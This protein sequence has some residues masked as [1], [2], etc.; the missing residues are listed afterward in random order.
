M[1]PFLKDLASTFLRHYGL[2][3][4][5]FCFVVPNKRSGTFLH[6]YFCQAFKA[7][8]TS[9]D[10]IFVLPRIVTITDFVTEL[11]GLVVDSRIDTLFTLF[12]LYSAKKG[13]DTDFNR[14]RMWGE[15]ALADFN[16]VDMFCVN[17]H[18]LFHNLVS[19]NEIATDYLT[20]EQREVVESY[21]PDYAGRRR[22]ESFW[23]HFNNKSATGVKYLR[24]WET[25]DDLYHQLDAA[26]EKRGLCTSGGAYR[27]ALAAICEKGAWVLPY[28]QVVFVGFNALTTV[29][30][31]IFREIQK[32]E[33][34]LHGKRCSLGDYY[35]DATGEI[36]NGSNSA[37]HFIVRDK[38][39]FP[40]KLKL[41]ESSCGTGS[42]NRLTTIACPGNTVQT[43]VVA[44][45]LKELHNDDPDTVKR[46]GGVVVAM[47][48]EGLFFPMLYSLPSELKEVNITMGYPLKVTATFSWMRLLRTLHAHSR[49]ERG[50]QVFLR[51]DMLIFLAHPLSRAI[52]GSRFCQWL[53][54]SIRG[55]N[56]FMTDSYEISD[57]LNCDEITDPTKRQEELDRIAGMKRPCTDE[58]LKL[59]LT[60]LDGLDTPHL[61]CGHLLSIITMAV[62][63]LG[64]DSAD[65]TDTSTLKTE[66]EVENLLTYADAVSRFLDA[67][68]LH[69]IKMHHTTT[70][71]LIN[72]LLSS[73][74]ISL[75]GEPL[76]GVQIMGMLETRSLDFDN[77]IVTSLNERI[78]P[79]R[80]RNRSFIPN[81]LRADCGMATTRFQ[82]SIFAYYFYRMISRARNVWLL[83]DSRSG[84]LRSGD[85][86]RYIYQLR[87][88][89]PDKS[90]IVTETRRVSVTTSAPL[91]LTGE[92]TPVVMERLNKYLDSES[93]LYLSASALKKYFKCPLQ[94]YFRYI[95]RIKVREDEDE[96]MTAALQGSIFHDTMHDLYSSLP[97][98]AAGSALV[99][100]EIID[101]W[102]TPGDNNEAPVAG[103]I[104]KNNIAAQYLRQKDF[105]GN[106]RGFA[107]IYFD[108]IFYYVKST[109]AADRLT[110]PFR[111]LGGEE[112]QTACFPLNDDEH[113]SVNMKYIIDRIDE[114]N[115]NVRLIDYKTGS[116]K[117][118][119]NKVSDLFK[120]REAIMQ[121]M[122]YAS[123]KDIH[124]ST[125]APLKICIA[126]PAQLNFNGFS[127]DI[128]HNGS[129]LTSHLDIKEEFEAEL[130]KRLTELFDPQTPFCQTSA[131][132]S[133]YGPCTYCDYAGLCGM[134]S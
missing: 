117:T 5:D 51:D 32:I 107:D 67:A 130:R 11:C 84:G 93:G 58:A 50:G 68:T 41:T 119:F 43:K 57:I 49:N 31:R 105:D 70:F 85:P 66:L 121:L 109:L 14:F 98:D 111:F 44:Q 134:K 20:D 101:R 26:L 16:D 114:V 3:L 87:Y 52:M 86:S 4:K 21:F 103:R 75:K 46:A 53:T 79:R 18:K 120:D 1:T 72:Q 106:L 40:S 83:Y 62:E 128:T 127:Y 36:L 60:P 92:K 12:K 30:Y 42:P 17:P 133:Q 28:S 9:P 131:K 19:L 48:D 27:R 110:T 122:L 126:R 129:P 91:P 37:A 99:T 54:G 82:E 7:G 78:F 112:E 74:T 100:A 113:R 33:V 39:R 77:V 80:L 6:N 97:R 73:E 15:I 115:G 61:L 13:A 35:W 2:V 94:F 95:R 81:S 90:H 47:P 104:L 125:S 59:L 108:P 102:L 38:L 63:S 10:D 88:L 64:G 69:G 118:D 124:D 55:R 22:S 24:L 34:T 123:L 96:A 116:D 45:I 56:Q 23:Q 8:S 71:S 25:L 76:S 89:Y 132:G 29:E 65:H